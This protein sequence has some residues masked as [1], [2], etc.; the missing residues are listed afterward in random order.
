M[1]EWLEM[2]VDVSCAQVFERVLWPDEELFVEQM[3]VGSGR[4]VDVVF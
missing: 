3:Q 1:E 2:G 4:L